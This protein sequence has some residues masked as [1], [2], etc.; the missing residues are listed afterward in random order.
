MTRSTKTM[1]LGLLIMIFG[2]IIGSSPAITGLL[3]ANFYAHSTSGS[4]PSLQDIYAQFLQFDY[5]VVAIITVGF[6]MGIVG[7]F[8][9]D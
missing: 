4:V 9:R 2:A 5:L 7:F 8:I 3:L 6:I 1:F